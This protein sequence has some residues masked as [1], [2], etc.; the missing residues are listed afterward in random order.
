MAMSA[1]GPTHAAVWIGASV[2]AANPMSFS[3]V[4]ANAEFLTV[5]G[6]GTLGIVGGD[7]I[8]NGDGLIGTTVLGGGAGTGVV[9]QSAGTITQY[10]GGAGLLVGHNQP[11][12]WN[13]SAGT[14]N[15]RVNTWIG[16]SAGS[17]GSAM[18]VSG[19][20]VYNATFASGAQSLVIGNAAAG[21]F[22]YSG[23]AGSSVTVKSDL[24]VGLGAAGTLELEGSGGVFNQGNNL[25]FDRD[26]STLSVVLNASNLGVSGPFNLFNTLNTGT[27]GGTLMMIKT[28]PAAVTGSDLAVTLDV[29]LAPGTYAWKV[30]DIIPAGTYGV[31]G[32]YFEDNVTAGAGPIGYFNGL[33]DDATFTVFSTPTST[34][35]TFRIDYDGGSGNDL[36][37][38]TTVVAP[39]PAPAALPAGAALLALGAMRRR[40]DR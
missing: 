19:T 25:T 1:G 15:V 22:R 11:G 8:Y 21:T 29:D 12:Q 40:R 38:S 26:D 14:L 33:L 32:V 34:A 5:G 31:S 36:V 35:Y 27:V 16:H 20:G 24:R 28:D 13:L 39:V 6:G 9:N 17:G 10:G 18:S 3:A 4:G 7:L 2:N 37:L 30:I 23:G